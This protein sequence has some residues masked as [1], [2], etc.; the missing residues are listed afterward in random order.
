MRIEG[1]HYR[2]WFMRVL[3]AVIFNSQF[4]ILNSTT[5]P[6][7]QARH[8]CQLLVC[9]NENRVTP[10]SAYIRQQ[11]LKQSDS[12]TIEQLFVAYV[13]DYDGWQ[14]LRVFPHQ[15]TDGTV[16][17]YS[18]TDTLPQDMSEEHQKYI[19]EV[20]PRVLMEIQAGNWQTVDAY[21]D[22]MVQ[23]QC[24]YG[25]VPPADSPSVF[26]CLLVFLLISI[27]I[28]VVL[29][30]FSIFAPKLKGICRASYYHS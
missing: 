12:L 23:Y 11:S 19:H 27:L 16:S 6:Q 13:F 28:A 20:F 9:D 2:I 15:R 1:Y 21:I 3:L 29:L 8:F 26:T 17:W 7:Q 18:A 4:S 5:L 22:R 25:A 30:F 24:K 10:L 14:T